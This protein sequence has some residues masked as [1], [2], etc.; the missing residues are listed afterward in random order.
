[1]K[2]K[3]LTG[4]IL[5]VLVF[6]GFAAGCNQATVGRESLSFNDELPEGVVITSLGS[7]ISCESVT[8]V[9]CVNGDCETYHHHECVEIN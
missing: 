4:F 1:M 5:L 9:T 8:V 7:G 6:A 2:N 3:L